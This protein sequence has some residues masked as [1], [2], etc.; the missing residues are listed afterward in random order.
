MM[1]TLMETHA[2]LPPWVVGLIVF[3]LLIFGLFVVRGIGHGR[4]HSK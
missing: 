1:W 2:G 4:P 3:A